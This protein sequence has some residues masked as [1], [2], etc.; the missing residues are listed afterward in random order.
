M[1][2]LMMVLGV[3]STIGVIIWRIQAASHAAREISDFAKG[4]AGLPRRMAFRRRAGKAGMQLV[5]DP[6]EAAVILMLEIARARG[7]VTIGQKQR[8]QEIIVEQF[9]FDQA[10]ADEIL[11]QAAWVSAP[12][13]GTDRLIRQMVKIILRDVSGEDVV[14][15]DDM[16]IQVSEAEGQP[17]RVQLGVLQ[18]F[19]RM[20]GVTV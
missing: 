7:E 4:A 10:E 2:I 19:R 17:T 18:S 15:L 12:D 6:R 9:E 14:E 16:L 20:A 5:N 3:L 8:I 11:T 1:H 13:A